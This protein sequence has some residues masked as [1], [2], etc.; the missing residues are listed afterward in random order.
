MEF[1]RQDAMKDQIFAILAPSP[2]PLT[3]ARLDAES[4]AVA[5]KLAEAT[6]TVAEDI[7][8]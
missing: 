7:A 6:R 3:V 1:Y 4:A 2:P 8:R 5:A